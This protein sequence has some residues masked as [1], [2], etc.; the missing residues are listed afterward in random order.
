M[1]VQ[2]NVSLLL[3]NTFRIPVSARYFTEVRR[4]EDLVELFGGIT[5]DYALLV[6]GQGSNVLFTRDFEGMVVHIAIPSVEA[7]IIERK[8]LVTAGAG[9]GWNTLVQYCVNNGYS[10]IENLSLIPGTTGA[11]PVQ[12]IGAYGVELKDV[13]HSLRAYDLKNGAFKEFSKAQCEFGYRTSIFKTREK[14]RY[15]ITSVCLELTLDPVIYASYGT[16]RAQLEQEGI[17]KPSIA[18]ISRMVSKIRVEKLPDPSMIGNAG[19]FFKNPIIPLAQLDQLKNQFPAII[20]F[21]AGPGLVKVAAGWLIEYCGF[22]GLIFGHTGTWKNQALV[23]VNYG[24]ASGQEILAFA[25]QIISKVKET[26]GIELESEV[27]IF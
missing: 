3:Y 21:E 16:L 18:D 2:E 6:L 25:H 10:G 26:F 8:V 9:V 20:F 5:R 1:V 24:Q 11:S 7:Q 4:E 22:K 15:I 19:S 12:N 14:G 17:T 23:L 27:N 13:F